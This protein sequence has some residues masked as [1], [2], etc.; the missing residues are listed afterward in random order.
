MA[1]KQVVIHFELLVLFFPF[2]LLKFDLL[3]QSWFIFKY[4][5]KITADFIMSSD[6]YEIEK[7]I[8]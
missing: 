4:V 5:T 2:Y 7:Q 8:V 1:A 3:I 6:L